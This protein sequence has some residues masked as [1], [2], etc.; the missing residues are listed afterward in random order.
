MDYPGDG[1]DQSRVLLGKPAA[2]N[3]DMFWEYGRNN[4]AF[5]YPR[6][7]DKSPNL[8]IRSGNW[9]LLMNSDGTDIQLYNLQKDKLEAVN[10]A[11]SEPA[12]AT[13]LKEKML[14]WWNALPKLAAP[15]S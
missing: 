8:A 11:A 3:K 15:G 4:I 10:V 9:K 6:P 13:K 12:I 5:K 14:H 2:R 1:V 7:K